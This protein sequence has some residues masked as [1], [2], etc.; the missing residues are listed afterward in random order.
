MAWSCDESVVIWTLSGELDFPCGALAGMLVPT[1][2]ARGEVSL[3]PLLD[4]DFTEVSI[5]TVNPFGLQI[6]SRERFNASRS[7]S[8]YPTYGKD[9]GMSS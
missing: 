9:N 1:L 6:V 4:G 5:F 2:A 8:G 3:T 7:I